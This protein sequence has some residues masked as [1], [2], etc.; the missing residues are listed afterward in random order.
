MTSEHRDRRQR[1]AMLNLKPHQLRLVGLQSRLTAVVDGNGGGHRGRPPSYRLTSGA[2]VE[3]L[4]LET[5]EDIGV[6]GGG[7]AD[8]GVAED[9]L[10]HTPEENAA[11]AQCLH[12]RL[13]EGRRGR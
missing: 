2:S 1:F 11:T 4:A 6:N 8:V 12:N 7:G 9:F 10:D 5:E 13:P 3:G